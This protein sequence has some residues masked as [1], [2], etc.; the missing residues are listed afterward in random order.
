MTNYYLSLLNDRGE[1]Y[2]PFLEEID[3]LLKETTFLVDIIKWN[4]GYK[5]IKL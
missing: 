4:D 5:V 2:I 1:V 3:D